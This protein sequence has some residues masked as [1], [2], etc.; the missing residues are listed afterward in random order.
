MCDSL[1]AELILKS[2][3]FR[4]LL[5]NLRN[6]RKIVTNKIQYAMNIL[7]E[8]YEK[9]YFRIFVFEVQGIVC[10]SPTESA[11]EGDEHDW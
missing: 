11:E 7:K 9:P 2:L 5:I 10:E 6:L 1:L 8:K 4:F 3:I